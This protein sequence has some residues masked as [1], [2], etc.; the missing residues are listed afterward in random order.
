[1]DLRIR[2][3]VPYGAARVAAAARGYWKVLSRIFTFNAASRVL[4]RTCGFREVGIYEKHG[5]LDGNWL[6]V[7]VERLLPVSLT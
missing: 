5:K 7:I 6:V 1:M 4:C 3:A 2:L